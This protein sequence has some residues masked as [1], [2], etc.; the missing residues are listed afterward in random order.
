MKERTEKLD[1]TYRDLKDSMEN[2][3]KKEVELEYYEE[4]MTKMSDRVDEDK[5]RERLDIAEHIHGT[6]GQDLAISKQ[7]IDDLLSRGNPKEMAEGLRQLSQHIK[8]AIQDTRLVVR[9]MNLRVLKEYGL[10]AALDELF[11]SVK[12]VQKMEVKRFVAKVCLMIYRRTCH[13]TCSGRLKSC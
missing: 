1:L 8:S 10:R 4:V 13:N 9:N 5:E 12:S 2:E 7:K 6:V 3:R 11:L